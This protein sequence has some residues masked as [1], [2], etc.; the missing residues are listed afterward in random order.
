MEYD[1]E[2]YSEEYG[3]E[4]YEE[5]DKE[6]LE[7]ESEG[8]DKQ[9]DVEE[10]IEEVKVAYYS[11]TVLE[12][13]VSKLLPPPHKQSLPKPLSSSWSTLSVPVSSCEYGSKDPYT[14]DR[15]VIL[16]ES[17]FA[18]RPNVVFF[19]YPP[20]CGRRRTEERVVKEDGHRMRFKISEQVHTYSCVVNPLCYAGFY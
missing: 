3:D 10:Q 6:E 17:V 1:G 14:G 9:E 15:P 18:N 19:Q 7:Y 16:Q 13:R 12:K 11:T 5:S 20:Q 2:E 8:E 4:Y